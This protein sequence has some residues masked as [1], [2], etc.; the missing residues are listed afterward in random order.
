MEHKTMGC[1]LRIARVFA[2]A[3]CLAPMAAAAQPSTSTSS[4][5]PLTHPAQHLTVAG[6]RLDSISKKVPTDAEKPLAD[7][8][9]HF[10]ELTQNYRAHGKE[11]GPPI[12]QQELNSTVPGDWKNNFSDVE[13]DLA[14][15]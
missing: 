11:I 6:Q 15:L 1:S 2:A 4:T 13:R 5:D 7:L 9:K 8:R 3:V 14:V 12:S 10:G